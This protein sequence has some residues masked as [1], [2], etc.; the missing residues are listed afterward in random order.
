VQPQVVDA[1]PVVA[2]PQQAY[3]QQPQQAY[4]QQPQQAYAQQPQQAYA[5]QPQQ[6]YASPGG[7]YAPQMASGAQVK[8]F[9][10]IKGQWESGVFD[11]FAQVVPSCIMACF[12][13]PCAYP[14][15]K[16]AAGITTKP[17]SG[18][19]WGANMILALCVSYGMWIALS[20][21]RAIL[22]AIICRAQYDSNGYYTGGNCYNMGFLGSI[23]WDFPNYVAW[24]IYFYFI[25]KL[26]IDFR[27]AFQIPGSPAEDCLTACCCGCCV[28]AQMLRHVTPYGQKDEIDN[29]LYEFSKP[30]YPFEPAG[31]EGSSFN[32]ATSQGNPAYTY[33]PPQQQGQ[34]MSEPQNSYAQADYPQTSAT[35]DYPQ[36]SATQNYPQTTPGGTGTDQL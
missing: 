5:Q 2:Q 3:A 6:A 1:Q 15:I 8:R 29:F 17:I 22:W 36:T 23:F 11:C 28:I 30:P 14:R 13:A 18:A 4:A 19:R 10:P 7:F 12:C 20:I 21:L 32:E 16:Y 35:Q 34:Q 31:Q 26:R 24:L 25:F 9:P 27:Q 33:V